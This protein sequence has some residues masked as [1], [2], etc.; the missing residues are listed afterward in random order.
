MK[1]ATSFSLLVAAFLLH[2]CPHGTA[3][4]RRGGLLFPAQADLILHRV[5]DKLRR[6]LARQEPPVFWKLFGPVPCL[7]ENYFSSSSPTCSSKTAYSS[8]T[9]A[10]KASNSCRPR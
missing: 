7:R 1:A 10:R 5:S 9:P 4:M 6:L 3:L 2:L 8:F